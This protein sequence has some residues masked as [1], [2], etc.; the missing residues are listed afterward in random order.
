M[1]KDDHDIGC[2]CGAG[3]KWSSMEKVGVQRKP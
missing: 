2:G 1:S 3:S